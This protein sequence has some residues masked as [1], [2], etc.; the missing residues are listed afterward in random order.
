MSRTGLE[1][2]V[3]KQKL[4]I[5]VDLESLINIVDVGRRYGSG[6]IEILDKDLFITELL[7]TLKTEEED[8]STAIHLMLDSVVTTMIDN[9]CESVEYAGWDE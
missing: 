2:K 8:G 6:D 4:I 7:E 1:V 5:S 3:S 9:G